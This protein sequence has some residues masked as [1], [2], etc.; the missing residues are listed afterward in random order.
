[1]G[2]TEYN[3]LI[4]NDPRAVAKMLVEKDREIE[5]LR[6][7]LLNAA[8]ARFGSKRRP[9][10]GPGGYGGGGPQAGFANFT[11]MRM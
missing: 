10:S 6:N 3:E 5:K 8:K 4:A 11:G 9:G 7:H 1:M 2:E